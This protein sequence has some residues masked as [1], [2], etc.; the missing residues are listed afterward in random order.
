MSGVVPSRGAG[1]AE[2][3]GPP[4]EWHAV[5]IGDRTVIVRDVP[6]GE[7]ECFVVSSVTRNVRSLAQADAVLYEGTVVEPYYDEKTRCVDFCHEMAASIASHLPHEFLEEPAIR[8]ERL[9][10]VDLQEVLQP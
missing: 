4:Y 2:Q 10:G 8:L 3:S 9:P 7:A 6:E 1:H 5:S